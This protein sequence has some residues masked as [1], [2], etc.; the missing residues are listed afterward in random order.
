MSD[1]ETTTPDVPGAAAP[2]P[3]PDAPVKENK[4]SND[5][6]ALLAALFHPASGVQLPVGAAKTVVGIQE[7]LDAEM[8]KRGIKPPQVAQ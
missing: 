3:T 8:L 2:Q 1:S 7:Y 5:A 4:L 6:V